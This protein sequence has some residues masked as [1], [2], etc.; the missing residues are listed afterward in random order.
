MTFRSSYRVAPPELRCVWMTGGVL[1]YQLC[2]RN[3]DCAHCPLDTAMRN[4]YGR[5]GESAPKTSGRTLQDGRSYTAEHCWVMDR[6]AGSVRIGIEPGLAGR[7]AQ[8]DGISLP[9][10]GRLVH[11]RDACA[12]Y[13]F[14]EAMVPIRLPFSL[15]VVDSNREVRSDPSVVAKDPYEHGWLLDAIVSCD[16]LSG[17]TVMAAREAEKVYTHDDEELRIAEAILERQRTPGIGVTMHD[18]GDHVH[19][20]LDMLG[21][22]RYC[23]L[24]GNIYCKVT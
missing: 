11:E 7:L 22:A 17:R 23:A 14:D 13:R 15:T 20:L 9:P 21:S 2:D 5:N 18:G 4:A 24:I 8:A 12:W 6:T 19:S 10:A 3:F 16:A 1:T